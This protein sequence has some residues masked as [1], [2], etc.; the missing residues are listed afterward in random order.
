MNSSKD[1]M[2]NPLG[3]ELLETMYV[4]PRQL[5]S[6]RRREY[7]LRENHILATLTT[8][9]LYSDLGRQWIENEASSGR[10]DINTPMR[11]GI[12]QYQMQ[13]PFRVVRRMFERAGP[14][15]TNYIFVMIYGSFEAFLA[16]LVLDAF[17]DQGYTDPSEET[18]RLMTGVQWVGKIDRISQVFKLNLGKRVRR[19]AFHEMSMESMGRQID[20]PADFLQTL[21][22]VRH[23]IVHYSGRVD[24]SLAEE[25][26]SFGVKE[27]EAITLAPRIPFEV[28]FF[29]IHFSELFDSEFCRRFGWS[30]E[31]IRVEL[32]L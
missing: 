1:K 30:R 7:L 23:R 24:R 25:F 4:L 15:L 5:C 3:M 9:R 6:Q 20:D 19:S 27:G 11:L 31:E 29:L 21:A 16:D 8:T 17:D 10:F 22:T 28:H 18:L 12:E 2:P 13:A 26:A 14:Q 32:L